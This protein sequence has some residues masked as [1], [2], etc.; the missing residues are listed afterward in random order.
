MKEKSMTGWLDAA[1]CLFGGMLYSLGIRSFM[2]PAELSPGGFTGLASVLHHAVGIP[3]GL[4]VLLLNLPLLILAFRRFGWPFLAKTGMATLM[5]SACLELAGLFPPFYGEP[6][7][8]ALFGGVC[9][10]VGLGVILLRGATTG[11][12]DLIARIL[13]ERFPFLPVGKTI[14]ALDAAVVLLSAGYY[15][16]L[17]AALYSAVA[18]YASS[19]VIDAILYGTKRAKVIYVFTRCHN[20]VARAITREIR[21]GVSVISSTGFYTGES[22]PILMCA[23]SRSEVSAVREIVRQADPQAFAIIC[24]AD[25]IIGQGFRPL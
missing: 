14:L 20:E 4:T 22:R 10:G 3:M 2:E 6:M 16:N 17:T 19:G 9:M 5:L 21:R 8:A 24:E 1:F 13:S 7:L 15:H 18:L 25:E 12:S 23:V 11:G